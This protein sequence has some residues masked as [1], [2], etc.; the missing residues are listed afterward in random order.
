MKVSAKIRVKK[1]WSEVWNTVASIGV[2]NKNEKAVRKFIYQID[3]SGLISSDSNSGS[4]N[5][6][7]IAT[8]VLD[9]NDPSINFNSKKYP[10]STIRTKY[11]ISELST[12][13]TEV[14][15]TMNYETTKGAMGRL[16]NLVYLSRFMKQLAKLNLA[17]LRKTLDYQKPAKAA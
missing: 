8:K 4:V 13:E 11:E 9:W 6:T 12:E 15:F 1:E 16:A 10:V 14:K 5:A 17:D 3:T 2:P 7:A